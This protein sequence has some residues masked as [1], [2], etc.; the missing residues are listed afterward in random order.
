MAEVKKKICK[1]HICKRHKKWRAIKPKLD[2]KTQDFV[3][4]IL[5]ELTDV[6]DDLC[7]CNAIL[8]GDWPT[9]A[10]DYSPEEVGKDN[11]EVIVKVWGKVKA[12]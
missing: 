1:C 2:A 11:R 10:Y 12:K 6:E 3:E 9:E 8:H 4:G 5:E 7:H